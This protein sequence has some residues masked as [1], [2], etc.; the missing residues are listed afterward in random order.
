MSRRERKRERQSAVAIFLALDI[1]PSVSVP[2]VVVSVVLT[3]R[4]LGAVRYVG[5]GDRGGVPRP[6]YGTLR[7][8]GAGKGGE[9]GGSNADMAAEGEVV[10]TAELEVVTAAE[11]RTA[12]TAEE[13]VAK[14]T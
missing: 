10:T 7:L 9:R 11:G 6:I 3:V 8:G 14:A 12:T 2:L 4:G 1:V 13:H 5:R